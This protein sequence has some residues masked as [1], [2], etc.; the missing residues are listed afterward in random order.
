MIFDSHSHT[1]FSADSNMTAE[2][3]ITRAKQLNIGIV[4]TEHFDLNFP[5]NEDFVFD[6]QEYWREY[7]PLRGDGVHLG[8]EIGLKESARE[9]NRDFA[10]KIPFD[11]VLGSIHLIDGKDLYYKDAY[12]SLTKREAYQKYFADMTRELHANEYIDALSH[13]DYIA[14]CAPYDDAEI[15]YAAFADEIDGVLRA[16]I[17]TNTALEINTRRFDNRRAVKELFPIYKR[18]RELGGEFV[19]VGS[20]AHKKDDIG[21]HFSTALDMAHFLGLTPVTFF[22]RKP[23]PF[24]VQ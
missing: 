19:T 2:E 22:E 17:D 10:K 5:G 7:A 20:D 6:P 8:A 23:Q 1:K 3:A 9:E 15:N 16:A 21:A 18:Y 14:R 13:I 4:F 24:A 12:E 11:M